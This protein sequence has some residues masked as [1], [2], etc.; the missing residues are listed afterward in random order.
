MKK[1]V[2]IFY[3]SQPKPTEVY[4]PSDFEKLLAR[5]VELTKSKAKFAVYELGNCVGDFS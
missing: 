4:W 2:I 3:T 1:Y 5:V